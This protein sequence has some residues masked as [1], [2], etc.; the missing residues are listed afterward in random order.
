MITPDNASQY[1]VDRLLTIFTAARDN[2]QAQ[3][4]NLKIGQ[5]NGMGDWAANWPGGNTNVEQECV[6]ALRDWK[7]AGVKEIVT[8]HLLS[9]ADPAVSNASRLGDNPHHS[10]YMQLKNNQIKPV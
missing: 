2:K 10:F 5:P 4:N 3:V 9:D 6:D 7:N 8:A 1:N